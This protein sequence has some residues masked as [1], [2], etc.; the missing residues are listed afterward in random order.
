MISGISASISGLQAYGERLA[1]NGNNIAN[2]NTEGFKK[3][4][5]ILSEEQPQGVSARFEKV[6]VPGPQVFEET[7][8]G[9]KMIEQSNV[10]LSEEITGMM[11]DTHAFQANI[12]SLQAVDEMTTSLLD[13]KA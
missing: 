8:D 11:L 6:D 12:K 3:G 7:V 5:V 1:N 2:M 13:I 10:D 9:G 4:R